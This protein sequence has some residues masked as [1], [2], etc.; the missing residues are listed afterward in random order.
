[1]AEPACVTAQARAHEVVDLAG[2]W[3]N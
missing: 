2:W 3:T 1:V